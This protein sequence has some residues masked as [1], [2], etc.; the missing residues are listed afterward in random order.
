M[1]KP[2]KV[3]KAQLSKNRK[4]YFTAIGK[5]IKRILEAGGTKTVTKKVYKTKPQTAMKEAVKKMKRFY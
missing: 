2:K 5:E 3:Q 1:N 4:A